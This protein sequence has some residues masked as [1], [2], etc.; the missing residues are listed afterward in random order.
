M[1]DGIS[2]GYGLKVF[3]EA[4]EAPVVARRKNPKLSLLL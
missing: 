3:P 4:D 2:K 1:F